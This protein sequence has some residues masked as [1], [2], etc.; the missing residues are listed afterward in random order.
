MPLDNAASGPEAGNAGADD[1]FSKAFDAAVESTQVEDDVYAPEAKLGQGDQDKRVVSDSTENAA[2]PKV[3][4]EKAPKV[5]APKEPAADIAAPAHWDAQKREAFGALTTPEARKAMIE[6]AKGFEAEFTRKTTE[7]AEN[8]KFAQNV[9]SLISETHRSQLR[10]AGMDEV[11]G[12]QHLLRLNDFATQ[13][14][15]E[16]ARWLFNQTGLDPRQVFPEYFAGQGEQQA[17]YQQPAYQP[18]QSDETLRML[19]SLESRVEGLVSTNEQQTY[20]QAD[21]AIDRFKS[22]VDEGGQPRHPHFARVESAMTELLVTPKYQAIEDFSE[23]LAKAYEVAVLM[24]PDI[25]TQVVESDVQKRLREQQ[26]KDDLAKAKRAS[27]P[28]RSAPTG[29]PKSKPTSID[30]ALSNAMSTVGV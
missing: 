13:K 16:Y 10:S 4:K 22:E 11:A 8:T 18:G 3:G 20:R 14:P 6:L 24:D 25:R 23:R 17:Q 21:R 26:A 12:I 19:R 28:I 30:D 29:A 15:D 7:N 27:A 5:E 9:K 2:E 1:A